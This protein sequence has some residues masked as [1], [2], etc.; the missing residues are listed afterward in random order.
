V[1]TLPI[2]PFHVFMTTGLVSSLVNQGS[3]AL[4]PFIVDGL[5]FVSH[6]QLFGFFLCLPHFLLLPLLKGALS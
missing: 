1:T 2:F 4:S 6:D 5:I 3:L